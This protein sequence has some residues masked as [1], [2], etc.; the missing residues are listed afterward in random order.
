MA[1]A[2]DKMKERKRKITVVKPRDLS[3]SA[4]HGDPR[5]ET[6]QSL[7][8]EEFRKSTQRKRENKTKNQNQNCLGIDILSILT[9]NNSD[10]I[11]A[12]NVGSVAKEILAGLL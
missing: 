9:Q 3:R 10:L 6:E 2:K 8:Q 12:G 11:A 7:C 1:Y 5:K 4:T